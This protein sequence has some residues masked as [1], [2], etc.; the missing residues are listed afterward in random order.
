MIATVLK[1][2]LMEAENDR[3]INENDDDMLLER[4]NRGPVQ[5]GPRRTSVFP[6]GKVRIPV[7]GAHFLHFDVKVCVHSWT[8]SEC[9][10]A[11]AP[12]CDLSFP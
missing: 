2:T 10:I 8:A 12:S 3:K 7:A 9:D 11:H 1:M 5:G 6:E 4:I